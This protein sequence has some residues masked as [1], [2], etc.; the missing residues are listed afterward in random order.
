MKKLMFI[1]ASCMLISSCATNTSF[2]SFYQDHQKDSDFSFGLNSS[3]V[4]SLLPDEDLQEIKPLLKKA[5]HVRILIFSE[6]YDRKSD[7]FNRFI[8]RSKF[9]KVVKVKDDEDGIA[10]FTLEDKDRI[11]EMVL[12]ISTGDELVLVGLKTNMTHNQLNEIIQ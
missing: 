5:K 3:L 11:K 7:Q 2:N 12:E 6:E 9:E 10:F 8:E 1:L 4:A